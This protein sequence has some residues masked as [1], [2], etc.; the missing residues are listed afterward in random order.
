[1]GISSPFF[2][3]NFLV[4]TLP[5]MFVVLTI[6]FSPLG[7]VFSWVVS[8]WIFP[9]FTVLLV[10]TIFPVSC[11]FFLLQIRGSFEYLTLF[12]VFVFSFNEH[13]SIYVSYPFIVENRSEVIIFKAGPSISEEVLKDIISSNWRDLSK[14]YSVVIFFLN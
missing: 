1:M 6:F 5:S 7:K 9:F 10:V 14:K 2:K 13:K 12:H 4:S 11:P 3:A 8:Y